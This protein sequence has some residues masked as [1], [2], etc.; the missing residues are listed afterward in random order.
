MATDAGITLSVGNEK[1][2]KAA[3]SAVQAEVK[4]LNAELKYTV[5]DLSGLDDAEGKS[6]RQ[7]EILR[8][9]MD[10]TQKQI[11]LLS[12]KYSQQKT[13]L[14]ELKRALA[15][16]EQAYGENSKEA[17]AA[18]I[19][20][21]RQTKAVYDLDA[22]LSKA[23]T[24]FSQYKIQLDEVEKSADDMADALEDAGQSASG[25]G[26]G[27][28]AGLAG[29]AISGVISGVVSGVKDLVESTTEYRQIMSTLE[30]SSQ[31]AGYSAEQ[32][33]ETYRQ[34]YGVLGDT[35]TAATATAN[36]QAI[37]L[38]QDKLRQITDG[39]IG[40]WATYGDSIPIDGLAEAINETV[41][42]GTV[43]G[44]F[45]DVLNWAGTSEDEFNEKL[46]AAST[47]A[48]RADIVLQEMA[49]QGL[50]QAA[51][52]WRQNNEDIEQA[53]LAQEN[54]NEALAGLGEVLSPLV[55]TVV[56]GIATLV[57]FVS[58]LVTGFM[59]MVENGDPLVS[60]LA[61]IGT[62]IG[63][64]AGA[65]G[66]LKAAM[67][68]SSLID[69]VTKSMKTLFGVLSAN[70]IL[71]VVSLIAGLVTAF[72]TAYNTSDEFRAKVDAAFSAIK[73]VINTVIETVVSVV[74]WFIQTIQKARDTVA[75]KVTAIGETIRS[76]F[77]NIAEKVES[78]WQEIKEI[79]G[80]IVDVGRNIIEGLWNG[81]QEKVGWVKE[82]IGGL[83]GAIKN[84]FTGG[85]GFD[86]NSPSKF[87]EQ[88][89]EY[90]AE[91]LGIGIAKDRTAIKAAEELTS[92]VKSALGELESVDAGEGV[93]LD[94]SGDS[95]VGDAASF[96]RQLLSE[97]DDDYTEYMALWQEKQAAAQELASEIYKENMKTLKDEMTGQLNSY[98]NEFE[99]V[100]KRL[101][102]G[103]AEGVRDGRSGVVNSIRD[104]LE[105]AVE[106]AREAL[107]IHSPSGVF[108]EIGANMAEGLGLG[109][110]NGL[111]AVS[112]RVGYGLNNLTAPAAIADQA[113]NTG[114]MGA[115]EALM[116]GM[117]GLGQSQPSG[118]IQ[119]VVNLDGR[120]IAQTIFDPL[121]EVERQRGV[122]LG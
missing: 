33:S 49:D 14:N 95:A 68:I 1:G 6:A 9:A 103:V 12:G 78:V 79:P 114:M 22:Q 51:E 122:V 80:K 53:N 8:N 106:A 13:R 36:L 20:V 66:A 19:S 71:A 63:V 65:F 25:V 107:D 83:V 75:E 93:A 115:V 85:D 7:A 4:A 105:A 74:E 58:D 59:Q 111:S 46:A 61:G 18:R 10:A 34:L 116:N 41:Q 87:T 69:T 121:R 29:G 101:M 76:V 70:P 112:R 48:E 64:V 21:D 43:T 88:V 27:F 99:S 55:T 2:F 44:T 57:G 113:T 72:I 35:Q 84:L 100:G 28:S 77:T 120:T 110:D 24:G 89:G 97:T 98:Y 50:M 60:I 31:Q 37:G 82:K 73:T 86:T 3:L 39:A 91:G 23:K 90:V 102:D 94:F 32:T 38:E 42:A 11:E 15:E 119:L 47:A 17:N 108:K 45:A 56:N 67:A 26:G 5:S 16:A 118:M 109:W 117:A 104:A 40:A 81:I 96:M 52:G 30:V 62:A 54:M 92:D